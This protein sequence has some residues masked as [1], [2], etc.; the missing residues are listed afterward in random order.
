MVPEQKM[1]YNQRPLLGTAKGGLAMK[2]ATLKQAG[3]IVSLFSETPS[4]QVQAILEA[5]L[6]ADLRDGNIAKVNRED[7]RRILGLK[8]LIPVPE[9]LI[10]FIENVEVLATTEKFI[11]K[12]KFIKDV[13]RKA[14][15]KISYI[16]DNFVNN[17][18]GKTEKPFNGSKLR[19]GKL[20][21]NSVDNPIITELGGE[22]EVETTLAEMFSLMEKQ[23]NGEEGILLTSGYAN[24]FYICDSAG[25]LWAVGCGWGCDGW[26]LGARSIGR[27]HY[28]RAGS[29][30]FSRNSSEAQS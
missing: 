6:L 14:K 22:Q 2:N 26:G 12:E 13:S 10:E 23:T 28:W 7:F 27:P 1:S 19:C 20:R 11:A 17:F 30:V 16:G 5:G 18:L 4:E 8:P 29:R 15:V 25:V 24:I 9:S 21:K 3:K